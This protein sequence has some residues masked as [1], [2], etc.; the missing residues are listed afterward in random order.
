[1]NNNPFI[2][3]YNPFKPSSKEKPKPINIY[4]KPL[5]QT[6]FGMNTHI[7]NT[8]NI[9][10]PLG[11]SISENNNNKDEY[12]NPFLAKNNQSSGN[13]T[14]IIKEQSN[15]EN[16]KIVETTKTYIIDGENLNEEDIKEKF[17]HKLF[18]GNELTNINKDK[19]EFIEGEDVTEL[20]EKRIPGSKSTTT[21]TKT[22]ATTTTTTT[23]TKII[24]DGG[25]TVTQTEKV[26]KVH[27]SGNNNDDNDND[28]NINLFSKKIETI[29]SSSTKI[30][31]NSDNINNIDNSR[32][33]LFQNIIKCNNYEDN[34]D[35]QNMN[36]SNEVKN[37]FDCQVIADE[38]GM[39]NNDEYL[40]NNENN[41]NDI[42]KNININNHIKF[43]A[44]NNNNN[45]KQTTVSFGGINFGAPKNANYT[46]LSSSKV[47]FGIKKNNSNKNQNNNS[48]NNNDSNISDSA[49]KSSEQGFPPFSVKN[50]AENSNQPVSSTQNAIFGFVEN[51]NDI[52]TTPQKTNNFKLEE[53]NIKF[54]FISENENKKIIAED[55]KDEN[56][57]IEPGEII[58]NENGE[59]KEDNIE[60]II[61][62]KNEEAIQN[63]KDDKKDDTKKEDKKKEEKKDKNDKKD[64]KKEIEKIKPESYFQKSL[65]NND[66]NMQVEGSSLFSQKLF[67]NN[68]NDNNNNQQNNSNSLFN[69]L[70]KNK[71]FSL[72]FNSPNNDQKIEENFFA[73]NKISSSLINSNKESLFGD[74]GKKSGTFTMF[75]Q[76][77]KN[78]I[79]NESNKENDKKPTLGEIIREGGVFNAD[80]QKK[81]EKDQNQIKESTKDNTN[82]LFSSLSFGADSNNKTDVS[83]FTDYINDNKGK[84]FITGDNKEDNK[85]NFSSLSFGAVSNNKVNTSPFTN[86]INDNKGKNFITGDNKINIV[87]NSQNSLFSFNN[88]N[89]LFNIKTS[90]NNDNPF[91]KVLNETNSSNNKSSANNLDKKPEQ[92]I[93]NKSLFS[94]IMTTK[95]YELENGKE[96][97]DENKMSQ[98]SSSDK[99]S[100]DSQTFSIFNSQQNVENKPKTLEVKNPESKPE[101]KKSIFSSCSSNFFNVKKDQKSFVNEN[102]S[103]SSLF[104]GLNPQIDQNINKTSSSLFPGLNN[105]NTLNIFG[106]EDTKSKPLFPGGSNTTKTLNIFGDNKESSNDKKEEKKDENKFTLFGSQTNIDNKKMKKVV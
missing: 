69:G 94:S 50:E 36:D 61:K 93:E 87:N 95:S 9:F 77:S 11:Q 104:P 74:E 66:E 90:N 53:H 17:G 67:Q 96:K 49:D 7:K 16:T 102:K 99:N 97:P 23:I 55:N 38:N 91:L 106:S 68:T 27:K 75:S 28:N 46:P 78:T 33:R 52:N 40:D 58:D 85:I 35:D 6:S 14:I 98:I 73:K 48:N 57:N 80:S 81:T 22:T 71:S 92:K 39:E 76:E 10:S 63:K 30:T 56:M 64:K 47:E 25:K 65:F 37:T 15:P 59:I 88:S 105:N 18:Q 13:R 86:Y 29:P 19:N 41:D 51:K 3:N 43:A 70:F 21:T 60:I 24:T 31:I 32:K 8:S 2:P 45:N 100:K 89:N 26:I 42:N 72:N 83:P 82:T 103:S 79:N 5:E 101:E 84:N 12:D 62:E 44:T 34:S 54:G 20:I 4:E 1:M